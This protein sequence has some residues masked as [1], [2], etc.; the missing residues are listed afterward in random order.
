MSEEGLTVA[1]PQEFF[2]VTVAGSTVPQKVFRTSE[3][4]SISFTLYDIR[5]NEYSKI[6]NNNAVTTT[7]ATTSDPGEKEVNLYRG[8]QVEFNALLVR[9]AASP[10]QRGANAQY[11]V[12]LVW[13]NGSPEV[14]YTKGEA[15]G[16]S[17]EFMALY[18]NAQDTDEGLGHYRYKFADEL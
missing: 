13:Q 17:F 9:G 2:E 5:A 18:D 14:V 16:L 15:A 1:H 7:P 4:L 11:E 10:E 12:P 3:G 8:V 6:L